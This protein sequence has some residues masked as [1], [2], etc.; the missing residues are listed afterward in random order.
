[1]S[2]SKLELRLLR[3][4]AKALINKKLV[5]D[6]TKIFFTD[7]SMMKAAAQQLEV[8]KFKVWTCPTCGIHCY[9]P[10]EWLHQ[11]H[12]IHSS[13]RDIPDNEI[14]QKDYKLYRY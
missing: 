5:P 8:Q 10:K 14:N 11:H 3:S 2:L 7:S 6:W 1:M 12:K 13:K 4:N 9:G